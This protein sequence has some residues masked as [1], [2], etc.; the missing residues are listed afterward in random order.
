MTNEFDKVF[1]D[2]VTE[3]N[4]GETYV[5][6]SGQV[7]TT[8]TTVVKPVSAPVSK[9]PVSSQAPA[10]VSH[11]SV[12]KGVQDDFTIDLPTESLRAVS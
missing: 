11:A 2:M 4:G 9:T 12:V 7:N 8:E 5:Q 3:E 1:G 10:T 6:G